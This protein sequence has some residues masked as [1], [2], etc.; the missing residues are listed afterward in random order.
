VP[1]EGQPRL[2]RRLAGVGVA[3]APAGGGEC[4]DPGGGQKERPEDM[5]CGLALGIPDLQVLGGAAVDL[6]AVERM[7]VRA[8]GSLR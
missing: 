1:W 4:G 5:G 8:Q 3:E 7:M 2:A 6:V